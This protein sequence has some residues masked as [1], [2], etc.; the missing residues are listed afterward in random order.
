MSY[1]VVGIVGGMILLL[2][3]IGVLNVRDVRDG[4]PWQI[5]LF[6]GAILSLPKILKVTAVD[7]LIVSTLS[8]VLPSSNEY[9]FLLTLGFIGFILRFVFPASITYVGVVAPAVLILADHLGFN[10]LRVAIATTIIPGSLF[11]YQNVSSTIA[12]SFGRLTKKTILN[13]VLYL[14]RYGLCLCR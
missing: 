10:P 13:S 3:H 11:I 9:A 12:Y 5:V 4:I 7:K 6:V 1:K 2:P 14:L 8:V